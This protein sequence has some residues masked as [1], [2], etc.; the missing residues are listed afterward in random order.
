[1]RRLRAVIVK[2]FNHIL[3]DPTSLTIVFILP[4]VMMMI[5]GYGISFDLKYVKTGVIDFSGGRYS[6]DLIKAFGNNK[7]FKLIWIIVLP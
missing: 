6:R 1:M 3:R 4:V 2:E 5:Y 7:Y